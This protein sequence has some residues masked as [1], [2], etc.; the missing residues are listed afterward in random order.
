M[1]TDLQTG[2]VWKAL[3]WSRQQKVEKVTTLINQLCYQKKPMDEGT[4]Q[5]M[6]MYFREADQCKVW[7]LTTMLS[8]LGRVEYLSINY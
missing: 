1:Q 6:T 3:A 5:A 4:L 2:K 7:S 8:T